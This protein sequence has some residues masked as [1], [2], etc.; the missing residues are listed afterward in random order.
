MAERVVKAQCL[1]NLIGIH[2]P[3]QRNQLSDPQRN[4]PQSH[5]AQRRFQDHPGFPSGKASPEPVY[6]STGFVP[7]RPS[8]EAFPTIEAVN[9]G[10]RPGGTP[11]PDQYMWSSF[12]DEHGASQYVLAPFQKGRMANSFSNRNMGN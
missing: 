1:R 10:I 4:Q 5:Y 6:M 2:T 8:G 9:R 3:V 11:D 7:G 12:Q